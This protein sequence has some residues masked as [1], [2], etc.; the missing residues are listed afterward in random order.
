MA[1]FFQKFGWIVA[2]TVVIFLVLIAIFVSSNRSLNISS[3]QKK[4]D[5]NV[6]TDDKRFTETTQE[7]KKDDEQEK[8]E[9]S[10]QNAKKNDEQ[11]ELKENKKQEELKESSKQEELKENSE[12]QRTI[13]NDKQH[14]ETASQEPEV[15]DSYN[16]IE[17]ISNLESDNLPSEMD[18]KSLD[19]STNITNVLEKS[20]PNNYSQQSLR[21]TKTEKEGIAESEKKIKPTKDD[22]SG[23]ANLKS[24]SS[25]KVDVMRI[26]DEGSTIVAGKAEPNVK[27]EV[28]VNEKVIASTESD[29]SGNFVA[30]G[31][32]KEES[33]R[34]TLMVRSEKI[35]EKEGKNGKI[36]EGSS[37]DIKRET[38]VETGSSEWILSEDIFVVLPLKIKTNADE[39]EEIKSP[40]LI[41]QS[42][43][44]D[45]KIVQYRDVSSVKKIT[46]DSISYSDLGEAILI[47]R[48]K[49][50]Y[51]IFIYLDN[52][53]SGTS[54]VG[55][56]GG[57]TKEL[58]GITPGIYKLR[59]DE[60][61]SA[62]VVQS[63]V[64][65]PFKKESQDVLM[66]MVSGS[67]T[68]QPGNSL[69]RIAR[70]IFGR[71]IRYIEIY[72]KNINLIKDPDLIYP[73]QVFSIPV[74]TFN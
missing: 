28:L 10:D 33:K 2:L 5:S 66:N 19:A 72:E 59:L 38:L 21:D 63:R 67:I 71:G 40:P 47:G 35:K 43:T 23:E 1:K 52:K 13:K 68:V 60:V 6:V 11:L 18:K 7:E 30:M 20:E 39:R 12:Q 27:V 61:D 50:F 25:L 53:L 55:A 58:T 74:E 8:V 26:D 73:G 9:S 48:A 34:S 51:K 14:E 31:S 44:N 24:S 56:S 65:T 37:D 70:R 15:N 16:T 45:I 36:L 22:N 54:E 46:I 69:W 29:D 41:V 42:N 62:G 17:G 32:L 4:S 3:S 64:E 49:P 57:W